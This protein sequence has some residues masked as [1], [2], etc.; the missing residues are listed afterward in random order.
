MV[1]QRHS[2][3]AADGLKLSVIHRRKVTESGLRVT[4]FGVLESGVTLNDEKV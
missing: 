4:V 3:F 2:G 1:P